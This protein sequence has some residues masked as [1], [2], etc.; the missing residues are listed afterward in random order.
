MEQSGRILRLVTDDIAMREIVSGLAF[1][2]SVLVRVRYRKRLLYNERQQQ[3]L[4]TDWDEGNTDQQLV[5]HSR[6]TVD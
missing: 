6:Q 4:L 1:A 3:T 2:C 5:K